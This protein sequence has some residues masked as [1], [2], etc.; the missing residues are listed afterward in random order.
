MHCTAPSKEYSALRRIPNLQRCPPSIAATAAD[1]SVG[2]PPVITTVSLTDRETLN[3]RVYFSA[4]RW[5]NSSEGPNR[6]AHN[7]CTN[8]TCALHSC[9]CSGEVTVHYSH[10]RILHPSLLRHRRSYK[11]QSPRTSPKAPVN[12]NVCASRKCACVTLGLSA[13]QCSTTRR[14]CSIQHPTNSAHNSR[15]VLFKGM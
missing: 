9:C 4:C 10:I 11:T 15:L 13:D 3:V 6:G 5:S 8:L 7:A 12:I 2:C 14:D 1:A